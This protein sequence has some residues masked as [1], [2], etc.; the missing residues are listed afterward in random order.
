MGQ[1]VGC[2]QPAGSSELKVVGTDSKKIPLAEAPPGTASILTVFAGPFARGGVKTSYCGGSYIARGVIL[3]AAHCF[4]SE[5]GFLRRVKVF[6]RHNPSYVV[7]NLTDYDLVTHPH[8]DIALLKF[9]D[10]QQ[11]WLSSPQRVALF[12]LEENKLRHDSLYKGASFYGLG[13]RDHD[14]DYGVIGVSDDLFVLTQ[15]GSLWTNLRYIFLSNFPVVIK[16]D[17]L[18]RAG[19]FFGRCARPSS[20]QLFNEPYISQC[21]G[22]LHPN[23]FLSNS[24]LIAGSYLYGEKGSAKDVLFCPGDSGGG[25][26]ASNGRLLGVL[27]VLNVA[28]T[29]G[30]R[31][32]KGYKAFDKD[33]LD[34]GC[35][36]LGFFINVVG[37]K[38]WLESSLSSELG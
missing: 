30:V 23:D 19:R 17:Y 15:D 9:D 21:K 7:A 14:G 33:D 16:I 20:A 32:E 8:V 24:H 2:A 34:Y 18:L 6:I 27:A 25:L 4:V 12:E 37:L 28:T 10:K 29:Q 26:R 11:P 13:T 22:R 3:T 31:S 5:T 36:S 1:M 35:R 38:S